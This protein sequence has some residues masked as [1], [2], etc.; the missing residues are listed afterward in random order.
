MNVIRNAG[1]RCVGWLAAAFVGVGVIIC[2]MLL[3]VRWQIRSDVDGFARRA[4]EAKG[5]IVQIY[6]FYNNHHTW[7]RELSDVTPLC[8]EYKR[9]EWEYCWNDNSTEYG[10]SL[11]LH[12]PYHASLVYQFPPKQELSSNNHGWKCSSEGDPIR[13]DSKQEIPPGFVNE[14]ENFGVGGDGS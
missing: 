1:S 4:D 3:F 9:K 12:G 7:P 11:R 10:P 2:P 6:L 13:M 5:L 8:E 14:K